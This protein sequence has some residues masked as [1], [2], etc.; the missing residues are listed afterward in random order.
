MTPYRF[1][2]LLTLALAVTLAVPALAQD[3]PPDAKRAQVEAK[4][5]E[6]R[7]RMLREQVGLS[8]A[9]ARRVEAILEKHQKQRRALRQKVQGH[10][11]A[12]RELLRNDSNDQ[13]AYARE[14]KGMRDTQR[15]LQALRDQEIDEL[16]QV[17]TPKEQA[18]LGVAMQQ[19]KRRVN[20][21][22]RRHRGASGPPP[23]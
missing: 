8:D 23:R 7:N 3:A 22:V 17:L 19:M 12:I 5:K 6:I 16:Q 2:A 13:P 20:Q 4:M 14:I 15:Q 1:V 9:T 11:Q 18:K 10:R 21:A